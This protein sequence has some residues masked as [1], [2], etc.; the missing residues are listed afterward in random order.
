MPVHR[1]PVVPLALS[2]PRPCGSPWPGATR[3]AISNGTD[4]G[5]QYTGRV[6]T[7]QPRCIWTEADSANLVTG[8]SGADGGRSDLYVHH[9]G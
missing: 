9:S 6:S 1:P 7:L 5:Q 2:Q 3:R 4:P 8:A